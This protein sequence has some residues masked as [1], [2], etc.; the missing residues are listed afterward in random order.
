MLNVE[1]AVKLAKAVKSLSRKVDLADVKAIEDKV[2]VKP[3]IDP[4]NTSVEERMKTC[5]EASSRMLKQDPS[6]K[7]TISSI[8][9]LSVDKTF[10]SSEG[11][12]IR[13]SQMVTLAG[14]YAQAVKG[15]I[16]EY[17]YRTLGGVGGLELIA[18][19][20]FVKQA[21]EVSKKA[22]VLVN[23]KPAPNKKLPVIL[24]PEFNALLAHEVM[25]HPLGGR[26]SYWQRS[27]MG[28]ESMVEG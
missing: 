11:T 19:L 13:Q 5:I 3:K 26:P 14:L 7:R 2:M 20:D 6:T 18:K 10:V 16:A 9:Y 4:K 12:Y 15:N 27:S 22:V 28:W 21:E 17:Y 25:G 23:A 1:K 8:G 24:D